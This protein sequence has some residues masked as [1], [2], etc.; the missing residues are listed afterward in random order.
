MCGVH[1]DHSQLFPVIE[2]KIVKKTPDFS[3]A[4]ISKVQRTFLSFIQLCF[5]PFRFA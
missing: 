1:P 3:A 2:G 4:R 5:H